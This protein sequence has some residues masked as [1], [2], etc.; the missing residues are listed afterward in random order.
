MHR[1]QWPRHH[2]L[3]S[4]EIKF[5]TRIMLLTLFHTHV[6][7]RT[8]P[9]LL[10]WSVK[11][12]D[13][14]V[15]W[16]PNN[17]D[18]ANRNVLLS[19]PWYD[20]SLVLV[21]N[22]PEPSKDS[23][24]YFLSFFA[25]FS[26]QVWVLTAATLLVSGYVFLIFERM[27]ASEDDLAS[28]WW[29]HSFREHTFLSAIT[30]TGNFSY[31]PRNNPARLFAWSLTFLSL[32]WSA[33]YTANLASFLVAKNKPPLVIHTI[34]DA[35]KV[36]HLCVSDLTNAYDH[37]SKVY[38]AARFVRKDTEVEM[39]KALN[40]GECICAAT[41]MV[42]WRT[43]RQNRD[44]NP[45]CKLERIVSTVAQFEASFGFLGSLGLNKC[46]LLIRDVFHIHMIKMQEDGFIDEAWEREFDRTMQ[47]ACDEKQNDK[48]D[49]ASVWNDL[50]EATYTLGLKDMGGIFIVHYGLTVVA[51]LCAWFGRFVNSRKKRKGPAE[52]KDDLSSSQIHDSD[53]FNSI[54]ESYFQDAMSTHSDDFENN[55]ASKN[56]V[57]F[58]M[59]RED[60]KTVCDQ[61]SDDLD[62]NLDNVIA[63]LQE[64]KGEQKSS[65][66]DRRKSWLASKN[67][68]ST[69][70]GQS[71][72]S[73]N[74]WHTTRGF[75]GF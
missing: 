7:G 32:V 63:Y 75:G 27:D 71:G 67:R 53:G 51:L 36:G 61:L 58:Q 43:H 10:E 60:S 34:E 16:W 31:T 69:K 6:Q 64:L 56:G 55:P 66:P 4:R 38:P 73:T 48:L 2:W 49:A 59:T 29:R 47:I 52:I 5:Q 24:Q 25:P 45:D 68:N 57:R 72:R 20:A 22:P 15:D 13:V 39:F 33:S 44:A 35:M 62:Q 18:N 70:K 37:I 65:T 21:W 14:C 23:G 1:G 41:T 9:D 26:W 40:N 42:S 19:Y 46:T 50:E 17:A 30:F 12:F 28:N 11:H 54:D 3:A 74:P 8:F